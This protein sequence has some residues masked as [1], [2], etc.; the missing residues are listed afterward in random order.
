LTFFNICKNFSR[1][2]HENTLL[3]FVAIG[4]SRLVLTRT[5]PDHAIHVHARVYGL[6][7]LVR[8][9]FVFPTPPFLPPLPCL[10]TR[11]RFVR[12]GR[13][14]THSQRTRLKH[15]SFLSTAIKKNGFDTFDTPFVYVHESR[16]GIG[17][18]A[19]GF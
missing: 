15:C 2:G 12:S 18:T 4:F 7:K 1:G 8:Y 14:C 3:M 16:T 9:L 11:R 19:R 5:S 6:I 13:I 10:N 17:K